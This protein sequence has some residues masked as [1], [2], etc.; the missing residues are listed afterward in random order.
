MAQHK[1]SRRKVVISG[2]KH[3]N[4][5]NQMLDILEELTENIAAARARLAGE[6]QGA[7][8][9]DYASVEGVVEVDMDAKSIGQHKASLR[10][11]LVDKMAHKRLGNEVA[12]ILEEGQ[13]TLNLILARI[14]IDAGTTVG[15]Y[16]AAFA[17]AD[18]ADADA[19]GSGPSKAS[20]RSVMQKALKHKEFGNSLVEELV[21]VHVELNAWMAEIDAR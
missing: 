17:I 13:L 12:D 2:L 8:S 21:A 14:D 20:F 18:P 7:V 3:K 19:P 11:M 10:K 4:A 1:S 5:A 16:V 9:V 6:A 15:G